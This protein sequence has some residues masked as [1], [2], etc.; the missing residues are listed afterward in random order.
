[1]VCDSADS[2]PPNIQH[3]QKA[4]AVEAVHV[5]GG[6]KTRH[7]G[8]E[9]V[10]RDEQTELRVRDAKEPRELRSQGHHDHEV[11]DVG[12]L[13]AGDGQQQPELAAG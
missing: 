8:R 6:G 11:E 9:R 13:D 7:A 4:F 1:M 2:T 12:E 5:G 3:Q 10:G